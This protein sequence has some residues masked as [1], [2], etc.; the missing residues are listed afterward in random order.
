MHFRDDP[1]VSDNPSRSESRQVQD[2]AITL[3]LYMPADLRVTITCMVYT[4]FPIPCIL[5]TTTSLMGLV[6]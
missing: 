3:H 1:L 5:N 4:D 2:G 6:E